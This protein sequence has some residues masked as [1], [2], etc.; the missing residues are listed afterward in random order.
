L[1][2][3]GP[4]AFQYCSRLTSAVF[5]D[6]TTEWELYQGS[7]LYACISGHDLRDAAKAAKY[8]REDTAHGGYSDLFWK[9]K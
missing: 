1:T 3:I 9:K 7:P 2:R 4:S 6:T 8:L 5:A